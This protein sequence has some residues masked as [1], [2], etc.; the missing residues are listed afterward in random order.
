M[1]RIATERIK[2]V[3]DGNVILI[4]LHTY[5]CVRNNKPRP[6]TDFD[7]QVILGERSVLLRLLRSKVPV[8]PLLIR[9]GSLGTV[10]AIVGNHSRQSGWLSFKMAK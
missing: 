1:S 9:C 2:S 10:S 6:V 4:F 3:S 8:C 5:A 7:I